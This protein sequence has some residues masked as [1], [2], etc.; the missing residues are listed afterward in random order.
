MIVGAGALYELAVTPDMKL[1]KL[2][3]RAHAFLK[4]L[5]ELAKPSA[6]CFHSRVCWSDAS[7]DRCVCVQRLAAKTLPAAADGSSSSRV[8]VN[9]GRALLHHRNLALEPCEIYH[10]DRLY[11][12]PGMTIFVKT[13]WGET[14]PCL[15]FRP[16]SQPMLYGMCAS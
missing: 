3:V 14:R 12:L 6:D 4:P 15:R 10:D 7:F 1:K 13:L 16:Y 2:Q 5:V 9:R 11:L 8:L